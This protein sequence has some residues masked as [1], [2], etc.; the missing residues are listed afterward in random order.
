M[1]AFVAVDR[2]FAEARV[3]DIEIVKALIIVAYSQKAQ[4]NFRNKFHGRH[5]QR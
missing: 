3:F 5:F 1:A 4:F 2:L